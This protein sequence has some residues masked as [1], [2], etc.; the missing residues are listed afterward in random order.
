MS[1]LT[2]EQ[3][4]ILYG[5]IVSTGGIIW[6][7]INAWGR[8]QRLR[9][10][11]AIGYTESMERLGDGYY[12]RWYVTVTIRNR[13]P[14]DNVAESWGIE[15]PTKGTGPY[16]TEQTGLPAKLDGY[17]KVNSGY[18]NGCIDRLTPAGSS[19][20][21]SRCRDG[22]TRRRRPSLLARPLA[23]EAIATSDGPVQGHGLK[24]LADW[25]RLTTPSGSLAACYLGLQRIQPAFP[26]PAELLQPRVDFLQRGAVDGVE[27]ALAVHA[28]GREAGFAQD[29][30]VLRHRGLR[31]PELALN[32]LDHLAC[33]LL[34]FGQQLQD[35]APLGI[36]ENVQRMHQ[37]LPGTSALPPSPV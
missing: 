23:S 25:E 31:D 24:V 27:A 11:V 34:A 32:D 21:R 12:D 18:L 30:Q 9:I 8:R 14:R 22:R 33:H 29:L 6:H 28:Y 3:W 19:R 1:K 5:M 37:R 7:A 26:E 4:A 2:L 15:K 35:A 36:T 17:G 16:V 20:Q 13:G 10:W